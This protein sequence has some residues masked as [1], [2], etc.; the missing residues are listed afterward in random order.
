MSDFGFL[1]AFAGKVA[2]KVVNA[3]NSSQELMCLG[4][5]NKITKHISISYTDAMLSI[6]SENNNDTMTSLLGTVVDSLPV[7][8]PVAF[9]NPYACTCCN[10]IRFHGGVLSSQ[11]NE[12]NKYVYLKKK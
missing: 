1:G 8:Y 12:D 6:G 7:G 5:C 10:K 9:G 4:K 2:G 11:L 3:A